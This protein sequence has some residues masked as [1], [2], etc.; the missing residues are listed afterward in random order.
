MLHVLLASY[1][2]HLPLTAHKI[3]DVQTIWAHAVI[4]DRS[5]IAYTMFYIL[6]EY[7]DVAERLFAKLHNVHR[8][9]LISDRTVNLTDSIKGAWL[10]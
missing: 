1:R 3:T 4:T 6:Y 5:Y 10:N 9:V 7:V 8:I 2:S